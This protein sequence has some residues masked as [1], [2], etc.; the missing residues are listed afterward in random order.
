MTTTNAPAARRF[1]RPS[2]LHLVLLPIALVMVA[3]L[4]WMVL[5]SIST[6]AE[7]RRFPPG[8]PSGIEW[9]NYTDA[10]R[11]APLGHWLGN[12][13]IVSVSCV[14]GNL[15]FCGNTFVGGFEGTYVKKTAPDPCTSIYDAWFGNGTRNS[16]VETWSIREIRSSL[17]GGLN[18]G[19]L[20]IAGL[21]EA[22]SLTHPFMLEITP[23]LA[24]VA[25]PV[26]VGYRV[27]GNTGGKGYTA[28]PVLASA[29][30]S[31]PGFFLTAT[32][33]APVGALG[34][35]SLQMHLVKTDNLGVVNCSDSAYAPD[36]TTPGYASTCPS[37]TIADV[38]QAEREMRF[39]DQDR[40][41]S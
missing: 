24:L 29:G 20:I 15:V 18:N 33:V 25:P 23:G 1:R 9:H 11:D 21:T 28:D 27:Y 34:A 26:G 32:S 5:L 10:L 6:E 16:H 30:V 31:T 12:S 4:L 22:T 38:D 39:A 8:L 19:N 35:G 13:A 41:R 7:T 40:G 3:P 17:G 14:A 36:S 2:P 37:I